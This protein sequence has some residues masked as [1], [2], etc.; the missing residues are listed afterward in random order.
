MHNDE[1]CLS[2]GGRAEFMYPGPL[3]MHRV[4]NYCSEMTR[5][6]VTECINGAESFG[7]PGVAYL[8]V[9]LV[10]A[11]IWCLGIHMHGV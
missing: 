4:S 6:L 10:F 5:K 3:T 2:S 11:S 7:R 8:D 9:V 1:H